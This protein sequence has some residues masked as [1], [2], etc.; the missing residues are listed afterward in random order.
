LQK[1]KEII[2]MKNVS[3]DGRLSPTYVKKTGT[4]GMD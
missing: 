4:E 1:R 3:T 2:H